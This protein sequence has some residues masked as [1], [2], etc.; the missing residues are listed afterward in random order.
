MYHAKSLLNIWKR[1]HGGFHR[2]SVLTK[3]VMIMLFWKMITLFKKM[4]F[5]K[6]TELQCSVLTSTPASG[7]PSWSSLA[8]SQIMR[9]AET[10]NSKGYAFI[11]FASFEATDI[12]IEAMNGQYLCNRPI[13]ISFAF[14]KDAKGER[15]GSA[16]GQWS[17][18]P[19]SLPWPPHFLPPPCPPT[20]I[21][22]P[23]YH[24]P[25]LCLL[26]SLPRFHPR[27]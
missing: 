24:R 12:A 1:T 18:F 3:S 14:K 23:P 8:C 19:P 16:A 15:H 6:I 10:G 26:L 11:N 9:D 7:Y 22:Y 25:S 20:T 21:H 27:F 17:P 13:S 4:L 2:A 5:F